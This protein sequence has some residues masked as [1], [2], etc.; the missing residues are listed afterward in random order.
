MPNMCSPVYFL[1]SLRCFN[2]GH[3]LRLVT[4]ASDA[5]STQKRTC[6]LLCLSERTRFQWKPEATLPRGTRCGS[7]FLRWGR[8]KTGSV[9]ARSCTSSPLKVVKQISN[10]RESKFLLRLAEIQLANTESVLLQ[11]PAQP[12][13]T[14][15][16]DLAL[17]TWHWGGDQEGEEQWGLEPC[18]RKLIIWPIATRN[19]SSEGPHMAG[20]CGIM[21]KHVVM[22]HDHAW[23]HPQGEIRHKLKHR[24]SFSPLH[25]ATLTE[26]RAKPNVLS[27]T[28]FSPPN[29]TFLHAVPHISPSQQF[30]FSTSPS[31]KF[32]LPKTAQI[33]LR[34]LRSPLF[35]FSFRCC[36]KI[37]FGL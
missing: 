28:F 3:A 5:S 30:L 13:R 4:Q 31:N 19:Q 1:R 26:S 29:H 11:N 2:P 10:R 20:V 23:T 17:H 36:K 8:K 12:A 16:K 24:F 25:F 22:A 14:G 37:S 34:I 6:R 21:V 9:S 27:T 7:Y 33:I 32:K 15:N 35:F 18:E